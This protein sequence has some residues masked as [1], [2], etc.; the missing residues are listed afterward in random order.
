MNIL[1]LGATGNTGQHFVKFALERGHK[2][3]AL[4]RSSAVLDKRPGLEVVK[5]DV[6]DPAALAQAAREMEAIVCCLGIRKQDPADPW[7]LLLSP[8]DFMERCAIGIVDAMKASGLQRVVVISSAGVGDS[9]GSVDPDL[10]HVIQSSSVG[11]IFRDLGNMERVLEASGLDTLA[12]RPVALV[13]GD[14]SGT[15]R[16]VDT[17]EKTSRISYA[18]VAL[19]MLNAVEKASPFEQRNEMIGGGQGA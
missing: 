11:K 9:W 5:G 10:R 8:E 16:I 13:S 15:A 2:V 6:L 7:S 18:N 4:V 14:T 12:V 3:R 1:T 19:W 17:F